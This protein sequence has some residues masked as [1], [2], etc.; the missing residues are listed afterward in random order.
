MTVDGEWWLFDTV[1]ATAATVTF[2]SITIVST[3]DDM[4]TVALRL[5]CLSQVIS[6]TVVYVR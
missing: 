3:V 2:V 1:A 4:T 6:L 5:Y